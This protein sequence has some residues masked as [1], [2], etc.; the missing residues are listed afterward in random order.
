MRIAWLQAI[1]PLLL[2]ATAAHAQDAVL[3]S[4]L[5]NVFGNFTVGAGPVVDNG[6]FSEL[7]TTTSASY[8]QD[9]ADAGAVDGAFNGQPVQGSASFSSDAQYLFGG[10]QITG[11]GSA[12]TTGD[13]PFTYV[14][15]GANAISSVR[16]DFRLPVLTRFTLSGSI[17]STLGPDV[18]TRTSNAQSSVQL[19]GTGLWTSDDDPGG[20]SA[21]GTFLPNVTYRL[22][23][24]AS[25]RINGDAQYSFNLLLSPVPEPACWL[26]L[27][28]GV[29]LLL[30]RRTTA[31]VT[32]A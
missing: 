24:N 15:L 6:G 32:R 2:A 21:S 29:P 30:A 26:L 7:L 16:L 31:E 8:A 4:R 22:A 3:S 5:T 18:G 25:T 11:S 13:T 20:F 27:A 23:G 12:S 17:T 9:A 28:I 19:T 1:P 14:S 10:T